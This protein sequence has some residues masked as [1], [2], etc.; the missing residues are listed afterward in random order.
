MEY[1]IYVVNTKENEESGIWVKFPFDLMEVMGFLGLFPQ[2]TEV[3]IKDYHLPFELSSTGYRM[4]L[5]LEAYGKAIKDIEG[6]AL[7]DQF[8]AIA[9]AFFS[10]NPSEVLKKRRFI[11]HY[12]I[13]N[14][15]ALAKKYCFY[16]KKIDQEFIE[17][18]QLEKVVTHLQDKYN[19]LMT[20]NG[21]FHM[22]VAPFSFVN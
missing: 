6:S 7:A 1:R 14:Y 11:H 18:I 4:L 13:T 19:L 17:F 8:M 21:L 20:S 5:K 12:E 10:G 16:E 15:E 3:Q 9:R 22:E 2:D